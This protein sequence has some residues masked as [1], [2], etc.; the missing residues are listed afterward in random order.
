MRHFGTEGAACP[1]REHPPLTRDA[2]PFAWIATLVSGIV[3]RRRRVRCAATSDHE[4]FTTVD[5]HSPP[6]ARQIHDMACTK[7]AAC[8]TT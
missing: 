8:E 4:I 7:L 6:F 2:V 3:S 5:D 1:A